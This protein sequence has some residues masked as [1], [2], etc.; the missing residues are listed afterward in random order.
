[1]ARKDHEDHIIPRSD[2]KEPLW[3]EIGSRGP[4][5]ELVCSDPEWH[6]SWKDSGARVNCPWS[7][8]LQDWSKVDIELYLDVSAACRW[9]PPCV[10]LAM[11]PVSESRWAPYFCT[12][13]HSNPPQVQVE[14][15]R[16]HGQMPAFWPASLERATGCVSL[17]AGLEFGSFQKTFY[18]HKFCDSIMAAPT[19]I[20]LNS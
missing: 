16:L 13:W 7:W 20:P 12:S 6:W 9:R 18:P 15:G 5:M 1:M 14:W 17:G 10:M 19:Y 3:T 2:L 4:C 8:L 11:W